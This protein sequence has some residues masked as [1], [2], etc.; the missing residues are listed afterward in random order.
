[1]NKQGENKISWTDFTWNPIT[2]CLAGCG[3]CYA[4]KMYERFKRSFKPKLHCNRLNEI[5]KI[6][7]P[8]RIFLG[9]VTDFW[10]EGVPSE[11]RRIVFQHVEKYP[12][13]TFQILTKQPQNIE[14]EELPENV[15]VGVT[16]ESELH[17]WRIHA[18]E[19]KRRDN[20]WT[21]RIF[22]SYEPMLGYLKLFGEESPCVDWIICGAMTGPSAVK[23]TPSQ[24]MIEDVIDWSKMMGKPI[25][26]K[27]SLSKY[28]DKPLIQKFPKE[29]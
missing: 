13:H 2:G 6:K 25:F 12:Q 20:Q 16:V 26:M 22:V 28:W 9:S 18:L 23:H 17:H 5:K 29:V 24:A 4:R 10:G 19:L 15:W 1:M 21:N 8:S 14:D 27:S 3:Y 7:K 11:W